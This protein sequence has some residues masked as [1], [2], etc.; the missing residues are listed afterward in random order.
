MHLV[1]LVE[2]ARG[3]LETI[4]EE[5]DFSDIDISYIVTLSYS[6]EWTRILERSTLR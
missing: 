2:Q 3:K 6:K 4:I 1:E 5:A